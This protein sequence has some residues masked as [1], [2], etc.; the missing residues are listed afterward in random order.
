[1][2][3]YN[4][5]KAMER[6]SRCQFGIELLMIT[7]S[8]LL[9]TIE[10]AMFEI[11]GVGNVPVFRKKWAEAFTLDCKSIAEHGFEK[12]G[13][14]VLDEEQPEEAVVLMNKLSDDKEAY[15]KARNAAFTFYS[16]YFDVKP[17]Y[18]KMLDVLTTKT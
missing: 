6:M 16:K 5:D 12:T 10:N 7:D 11:V 14:V 15:D 1:M 17:A 9:D 4:H 13:T 18:D 3:P 2:P 8:F